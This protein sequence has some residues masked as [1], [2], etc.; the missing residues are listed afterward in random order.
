MANLIHNCDLAIGSGGVN[1]Y[2]RIFLGLPSIV[3]GTSLNQRRNIIN[4]KRKK[5]II[6]IKNDSSILNMIKK[7][8]LYLIK[9]KKIHEKFSKNCYKSINNNQNKHLNKLIKL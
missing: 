8:I 4:S 6:N 3:I 7:K 9:N 2:E 1:L 5:L